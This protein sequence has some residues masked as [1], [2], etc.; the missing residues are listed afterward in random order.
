MRFSK[1]KNKELLDEWAY[2]KREEAKL[3]A[4]LDA[5]IAPLRERFEK[6]CA[7]LREQYTQALISWQQRAGEI[8]QIVTE[9]LLSNLNEVS[10]HALLYWKGER[11]NGRAVL[12]ARSVSIHALLYWKGELCC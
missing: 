9:N 3:L 6:K 5:E 7:P 12:Y 8:Q 10:I 11:A 4:E 1:A 2:A